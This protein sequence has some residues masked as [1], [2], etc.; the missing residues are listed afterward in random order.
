M[1]SFPEREPWEMPTPQAKEWI[2]LFCHIWD[3]R[4]LATFKD[5]RYIEFSKL[6]RFFFWVSKVS[7]GA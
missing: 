7:C 6:T 5:S 4:L 2:S 3:Q 1:E